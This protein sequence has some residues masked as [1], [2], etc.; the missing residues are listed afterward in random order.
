M[1]REYAYYL[2]EKTREDYN[3][4]SKEFSLKRRD[5]WPEFSFLKNYIKD[6]DGVLDIGCGNGRLLEVLNGKNVDYIGIDK[7]EKILKIAREK[8]PKRKFLIADALNL[9]FPGSCFDKVFAIA[10]FHHIPSKELR[11]RFLREA[12]RIL[13][14][15][16]LLILTVWNL[17]NKDFLKYHL[18]FLILKIIG[19]SKLDF[20]DIFYPFKNSKGEIMA[21]RYIHWFTKK[22]LLNIIGEVGLKTKEIRFLNRGKMKKANILLLAEKD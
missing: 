5:F 4:L 7:S 6:G 12:E 11:E 15:N 3:A 14:P 22:E 8:H 19:K 10:I 1:D 17:F 16:G 13:K 21:K 18:K 9:P 20:R 2:I